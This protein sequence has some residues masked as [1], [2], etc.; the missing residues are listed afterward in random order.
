V[1]EGTGLR[2]GTE[3]ALS[4]QGK[5]AEQEFDVIRRVLKSA[6]DRPLPRGRGSV[7]TSKRSSPIPSRA[8][9]VLA[10]AGLMAAVPAAGG[11]DVHPDGRGD[12][13]RAIGEGNPRKPPLRPIR[14]RQAPIIYHGGPVLRDPTVYIVWYGTWTPNEQTILENL[15]S[16]IGGSP[17]ANIL[18]TYSDFSGQ[19]IPATIT[20][21]GSAVDNYSLGQNLS[22]FDIR[23]VVERAI[24]NKSLP[25][26]ASGI[27]F[28]FT[29][30]D[31]DEIS[32][33]CTTFC[34]WHQNVE[35]TGG[36]FNEAF[37]GNPA[38]C[39]GACG[40][41]GPSPNNDAGADGAASIFA[42]E[43]MESITDPYGSAWYDHNGDECADKCAYTYGSTT[44]LPN[45]SVA[46]IQ[47]GGLNYLIQEIWVNLGPGRCAMQR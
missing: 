14:E 35:G 12:R 44:T 7:S 36:R 47:L 17:Y 34:G 43:L 28:V 19:I 45:G 9:A 42:H 11:E 30:E 18:T 8:L 37:I 2:R 10:V 3:E 27:Y 33:Q 40:S 4:F 25:Y 29:A 38:R 21:G 15:A 41:L 22:D 5:L 32:G 39:G 20:F 24:A 23:T 31:V 46:N 16:H 13:P 6:D 26:D 1:P